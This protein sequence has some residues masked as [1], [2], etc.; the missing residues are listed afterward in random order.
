MDFNQLCSFFGCP[1]GL[2]YLLYIGLS[3][4]SRKLLKGKVVLITGA[5]SGLGEACARAFHRAGCKV[6]LCGRDH[7]QLQR[8]QTSLD[9]S[10]D[11]AQIL[12][13]D[14]NDIGKINSKIQDA[15]Q[16]YGKVDIVINNAGVS[17]RGQVKDTSLE[18]DQKIMLVNYFGQIA[19]TKALLPH[20][21]QRGS[22]CIVGI[23]SIQGKISIPYRSAYAA[24]KH[25]FQAFYDSL[26]A[27]LSNTNIDVCVIS[28]GYIK[29]NLSKNALCGDGSQYGAMD[30]TT[31]SGM[32][33]ESVADRVMTAVIW[34]EKEV[35][36]APVIH[37]LAIVIRTLAPSLYFVLMN[38]RAKSGRKEFVKQS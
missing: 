18:T 15:I 19:L 2:L 17:Y 36:M 3:H 35:V 16:I 31:A 14:L 9:T 1:L 5:S 11:T 38:H 33:P 22:G 27:E 32:K 12:L 20:M 30:K 26:R 21:L 29:T 34:G 25:A 23:S 24:S 10:G 4:R 8:V 13:I 37:K 6:I 28:P 7:T